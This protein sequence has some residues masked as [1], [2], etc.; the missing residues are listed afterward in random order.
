MPAAVLWMFFIPLFSRT[1]E[2]RM[3]TG[4]NT[5]TCTRTQPH[6]RPVCVHGGSSSCFPTLHAGGPGAAFVSLLCCLYSF[7]K[8]LYPFLWFQILFIHIWQPNLYTQPELFSE[9]QFYI[10]LLSNL[11]RPKQIKWFP[12]CLES[13]RSQE[14]QFERTAVHVKNLGIISLPVHI[15]FKRKSS[16][17]YLFEMYVFTHSIFAPVSMVT[18]SFQRRRGGDFALQHYGA[19]SGD[20][21]GCQK[22]WE[23]YW[24]PVGREVRGAAKHPATPIAALCNQK[25]SPPK[26]QEHVG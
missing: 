1:H 6:T 3:Q 18:N 13:S 25:V 12:L 7:P 9:L 20:I 8:W 26:C 16:Q 5:D 22:Q 4:R 17:L 15:H 21:V 10:Q 19:L 2:R 14:C 24:N 23:C 11:I